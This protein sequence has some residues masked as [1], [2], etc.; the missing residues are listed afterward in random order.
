MSQK[1]HIDHLPVVLNEALNGCRR[2]YEIL[3][4]YVKTH[5]NEIGTIAGWAKSDF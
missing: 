1:F 3:D 5:L 2:I 4:E